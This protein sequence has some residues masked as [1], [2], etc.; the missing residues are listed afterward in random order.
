MKT[1][2]RNN[3]HWKTQREQLEDQLTNLEKDLLEALQERLE[4]ARAVSA[5]DPTEFMDMA[6]DS[7]ADE[8]A[9]RI[10]ESDSAKVDEIEEALRR[11][12]EGD[13][14]SCESC[15]E[16]IADKRLQARPFATLCIECKEEREKTGN[17]ARVGVAPSAK[18]SAVADVGT[19]RSSSSGPSTRDLVRDANSGGIM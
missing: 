1:K 11:L 18:R 19:G 6:S 8:L 10:A 3:T 9:A 12:R 7:E 2:N 15:G 17:R 5:D 16:D 13:Y 14:G 4:R